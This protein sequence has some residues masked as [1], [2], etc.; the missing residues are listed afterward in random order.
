MKKSAF[1]LAEVLVT[2]TVIGIVAMLALPNFINNSNAKIASTTLKTTYA[3]AVDSFKQAMSDQSV[4]DVHDLD[5]IGDTNTDK[6]TNLFKKY[7]KV[8]KNCGNTPSDC[9]AS[10]YKNRNG[11][12]AGSAFSYDGNGFD[13]YL[14]LENGSAV[15]LQLDHTNPDAICVILFDT[16]GP[17]AP[18]IIG[19]DLFAEIINKDG[20]FGTKLDPDSVSTYHS[21]CDNA[22]DA[23]GANACMNVLKY[24]NWDLNK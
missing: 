4:F 6:N 12:S 24:N 14:L 8:S 16:N 7:F 19:K 10:S 13:T 18:N 23:K 15:A 21:D 20:S 2:L 1:T 22:T 3:Q 11:S 9:F 17:D 5:F